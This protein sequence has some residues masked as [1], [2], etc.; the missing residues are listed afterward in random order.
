MEDERK[1]YLIMNN[2]EFVSVVELTYN[3]YT[4][5]EWFLNTVKDNTG[6]CDV[7]DFKY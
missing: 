4:L 6:F 7:A 1:I 5:I 2:D 3:E